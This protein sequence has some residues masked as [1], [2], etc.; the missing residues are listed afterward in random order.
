MSA[1]RFS[2]RP[3]VL[4]TTVYF[5]F[6]TARSHGVLNS[7]KNSPA[8]CRSV[9]FAATPIT[10]L[11]F[12]GS[13]GSAHGVMIGAR[14]EAHD[15]S[16]LLQGLVGRFEQFDHSKT[17]GAVVEGDLILH[18]AVGEISELELQSLG[19]VHF[20]RPDVARPIA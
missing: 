9:E 7:S 13:G 8:I 18:D 3:S 2:S 5:L 14:L 10:W 20:R 1:S 6:G 15:S 4:S 11:G 19:L 12:Q 16:S 17:S